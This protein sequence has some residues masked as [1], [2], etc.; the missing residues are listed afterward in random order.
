M[1]FEQALQTEAEKIGLVLKKLDKPISN[2]EKKSIDHLK[3]INAWGIIDRVRPST[4]KM[5]GMEI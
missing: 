2:E 4:T 3:R 5:G 1:T